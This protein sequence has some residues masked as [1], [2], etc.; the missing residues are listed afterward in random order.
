M[1]CMKFTERSKGDSSVV[2]DFNVKRFGRKVTVMSPQNK[3]SYTVR[4]VG[5]VAQSWTGSG[6]VTEQC[7]VVYGVSACLP[8]TQNVLGL[9]LKGTKY[10]VTPPVW[11]AVSCN[12]FFWLHSE[13]VVMAA[14][15]VCLTHRRVKLSVNQ[16]PCESHSECINVVM[17]QHTQC[18]YTHVCRSCRTRM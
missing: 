9:S 3:Q 8:Y 7:P 16:N 2:C 12:H 13:S 10:S 4:G 15:H 11:Q 1:H 6:L 14:V 18:M 17:S 5:D